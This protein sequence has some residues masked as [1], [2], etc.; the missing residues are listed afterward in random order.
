MLEFAV[1]QS[2][3]L[4]KESMVVGRDSVSRRSLSTTLVILNV[5]PRPLDACT[6]CGQ[7]CLPK[8]ALGA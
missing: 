5:R 4:A 6:R 8:T 7:P 2:E 1:M 3:V